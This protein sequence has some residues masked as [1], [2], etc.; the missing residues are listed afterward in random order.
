ME[1]KGQADSVF[2]LFVDSIVGL[3]I[4]LIILSAVGYFE[5]LSKQQTID[6]FNDMLVSAVSSPNGK[7]IHSSGEMSFAKGYAIDT[8][9]AQRLTSLGSGCFTFESTMGSI[10]IA[11]AANRAE[12]TQ[13]LR[14]EVYM[15]CV[16]EPSC[17]PG[18][19]D[20]PDNCCATC[21]VSFGKELDDLSSIN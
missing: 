21:I 9:T 6:D 16:S 4:F 12:F 15:R 11:S 1:N 7:V 19:N 5:E 2:R 20:D 10:K 18:M 13:N 8:I 3:A 17:T 14:V